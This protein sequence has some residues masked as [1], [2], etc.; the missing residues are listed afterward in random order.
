[1]AQIDYEADKTA[2]TTGGGGGVKFPAAPRGIYTLQISDF[3]DGLKTKPTAKNPNVPLTK[4]VCEVA[5]GPYLGSKVWHNVTWIPRGKDEKAPAGHGIA[6]HFLHAVGMQYDGKFSFQESDFQG[7]TFRALLEVEEYESSSL[8]RDGTPYINEKNVIREIYT[9]AHPEPAELPPAPT[10]KALPPR[11][12][13]PAGDP[14]TAQEPD[15]SEV[16]F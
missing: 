10:K 14:G 16:P 6:V 11:P 8:K 12:G 3:S 9:E 13:Q 2:E 4:F 7:R 15:L 5:E 1:M